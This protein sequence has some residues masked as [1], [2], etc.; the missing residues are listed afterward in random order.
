MVAELHLD[1]CRVPAENIV[2]R[3]GLGL[4]HVASLGLSH[5]RYSTAWGAVGLAQACL[6]TC[7]RYT[8]ARQQFGSLLKEHQLIQ[9]MIADMVANIG[10]ARLLCCRAGYFKQSGDL[11]SVMETSIAKYYASTMALQVASDAVQI[12]GANG[13]GAEYPVQRHLRD[14]KIMEIIEGST[15]VQQVIIAKHAYQGG[16]S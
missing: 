1:E 6:Q 5:G 4:T 8:N 13:C 7:L 3:I 11:R 15:Q 14:A 10:A 2:C 9:R 12:H 16:I